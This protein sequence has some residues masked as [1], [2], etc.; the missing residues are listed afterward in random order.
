MSSSVSLAG[1]LCTLLLAPLSPAQSIDIYSEFQRVDPFGTIIAADRSLEPR[2]I[3]SPAVARNAHAAFHIAVS[4]PPNQSYFLY[5]VP[6]PLDACVVDVY[7]EHFVKT[8]A[9]WVPDTL[10]QL[11]RLPDFGV[12][13]D[14]DDGVAAQDTRLY[15]LDLWIP[16]NAA[17]QR[18]RVEVQLK[19]GTWTVRPMEVRI[20]RARVPDLPA[21]RGP[22]NLPGI[23]EGADAAVLGPLLDFINSR[24]LAAEAKP[25]TV[26]GVIRRDAVQDMALAATLDPAAA[27]PQ[28][29]ARRALNLL[30]DNYCYYPRISGAEWYLKLRDY[31][32]AT[33]R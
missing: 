31:L 21:A 14:P 7:K 20:L 27:G 4:V 10:T 8:P 22:I 13:P 16:P 25:L 5:V 26:R 11:H 17:P 1:L 19:V 18:F 9:G 15:L 32:Y 3:L 29:L 23:E 24:P 6:N 28:A 33:A 12:T 30:F 2:E